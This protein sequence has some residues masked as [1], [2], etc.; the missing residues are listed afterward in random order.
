ML[1]CV[2]FP[3]QSAFHFS[4][5]FYSQHLRHLHR[6]VSVPHHLLPMV[7]TLL[8]YLRWYSLPAMWHKEFRVPNFLYLP[9][10]VSTNNYY[11]RLRSYFYPN[12][13]C[14]KQN[15]YIPIIML[16]SL[17]TYTHLRIPFLLRY[18]HITAIPATI[19]TVLLHW[20]IPFSLIS[21]P[22]S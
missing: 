1:V 19:K 16:N 15:H 17:Y 2:N 14:Y 11:D 22:S 13:V 7:T 10:R 6:L 12:L 3:F 21:S 5:I 8:Q 18:N 9:P 20:T 4:V